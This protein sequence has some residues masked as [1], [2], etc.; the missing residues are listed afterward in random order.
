MSNVNARLFSDVNY[1]RRI[2]LLLLLLLN[3]SPL[4]GQKSESPPKIISTRSGCYNLDTSLVKI[5][6]ENYFYGTNL[7]LF[8]LKNKI[9]NTRK[10][11]VLK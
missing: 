10:I 1:S 5:E 3:C 2:Q 8:F 6:P 11:L 4:V 7:F 9:D